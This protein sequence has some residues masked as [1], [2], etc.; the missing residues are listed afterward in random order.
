MKQ[1]NKDKYL[2]G[3][4]EGYK[5]FGAYELYKSN[6]VER[7]FHLTNSFHSY[8]RQY[9]SNSETIFTDKFDEDE[10]RQ[11]KGTHP[12]FDKPVCVANWKV[13]TTEHTPNYYRHMVTRLQ[14]FIRLL[15]PKIKKLDKEQQPKYEVF[16]K[17]LKA[18]PDELLLDKEGLNESYELLIEL[19]EELGYTDMSIQSDVQGDVKF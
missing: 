1:N 6:L 13:G 19:M 4:A 12:N 16:V 15:R 11:P 5:S 10:A 17:T 7:L 3:K 9:W 14:N 8:N 2:E 18:H